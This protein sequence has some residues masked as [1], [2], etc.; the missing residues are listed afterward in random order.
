MAFRYGADGDRRAH[1]L[2]VVR[3]GLIGEL[4]EQWGLAVGV[5]DRV[6]ASPHAPGA[7]AVP[8]RWSLPLQSRAALAPDAWHVSWL[9]ARLDHPAPAAL[10]RRV[11]YGSEA[12]IGPDATALSLGVTSRLSVRA[13]PD[14]VSLIRF[15]S[16]HPLATRVTVWPARDERPLPVSEILEEADR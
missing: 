11:V 4:G 5:I 13:A 1:V 15:N 2:E 7:T 12:T 14:S 6:S 3:F 8:S 9:Y 16:D 10:V